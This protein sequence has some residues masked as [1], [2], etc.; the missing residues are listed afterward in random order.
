MIS[1]SDR[2]HAISTLSASGLFRERVPYP[3][4]LAAAVMERFW[5]ARQPLQIVKGQAF[6]IIYSNTFSS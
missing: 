2:F 1:A 5:D 6:E 4:T 3:R